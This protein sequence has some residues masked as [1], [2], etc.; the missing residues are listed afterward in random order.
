[1]VLRGRVPAGEMYPAGE[2]DVHAR[3]VRLA[4][5]VRVRVVEAGPASAQPIVI[6]PGW[7]CTAWL[8][9]DPVRGLAKAGFRAIV[10][11]LKGQ[12][13]SDKPTAS[14]E[15]TLDAM[16]DNLIAV[17]NALSLPVAG[18]VGHSMGAAIAAH[19][20]VIAPDRVSGVA[21]VA[22]VGF[23]GVAGMSIFRALTPGFAVPMLPFVAKRFV[24]K[25]MLELVYG[26][27][28]APTDRDIDELR[29]PTQFPEYTCALRNLLHEFE[30]NSAFPRLAVPHIVIAGEKDHLSPSSDAARYAGDRQPVIIGG[31]GHVLFS[32]APDEVNDQLVSF[33]RSPHLP[34][35]I[36][37]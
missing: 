15:Y 2:R 17:L 23:A 30:W 22:P 9:R 5:G 4:S 32:E 37:S 27:L 33:F 1:M 16:R 7:G 26:D 19:A 31:A 36:S 18:L 14:D 8:Y 24:V 10:V 3:Y 28:T 29:A 6:V 25:A 20:A 11:E 21:L 35:Y 12:G 34:G 13:L